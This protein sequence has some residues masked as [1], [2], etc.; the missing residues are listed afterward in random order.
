MIAEPELATPLPTRSAK[1]G[2]LRLPAPTSGPNDLH[3][4]DPRGGLALLASRRFSGQVLFEADAWNGELLLR[5]GEILAA[6]LAGPGRSEP[7]FGESALAA[8]VDVSGVPWSWR[9]VP[10]S[11]EL[12]LCLTGV[13]VRP[14]LHERFGVEDLRD[15]LRDLAVGGRPGL[16][17]VDVGSSWGRIPVAPGRLLGC[18]T[19]E[20][21]QLQADL[22]PLQPIIADGR[23]EVRWYQS[24]G[25]TAPTLLLPEP[26]RPEPS[27]KHAA[28]ERHLV[29]LVSDF[30]ARWARARERGEEA[31]RALQELGLLLDRLRKLAASLET[32]WPTDVER[33]SNRLRALEAASS[34][35]PSLASLDAR[36]AAAEPQQAAVILVE[37]VS[38]ALDRLVAACPDEALAESCQ[39][40]GD[41]LEAEL[42]SALAAIGG[43]NHP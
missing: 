4:D 22:S 32:I 5:G 12:I 8:L 19:S 1:A 16:L 34:H 26:S 9:A 36:L 23:F 37:L 29:R 31:V 21:A 17:E 13:G 43:G 35:A 7:L 30:E 10:L 15:K 18:W 33:F 38:E 41:A 40:A 25:A 24:L 3:G 39:Q 42:R 6:G 11:D 14:Q 28:L 20:A 27:G 2:P